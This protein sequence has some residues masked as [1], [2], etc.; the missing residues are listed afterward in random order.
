MRNL[1]ASTVVHPEG[2]VPRLQIPPR[3]LPKLKSS[4]GESS[5][6][7]IYLRHRRLI[8]GRINSD[9]IVVEMGEQPLPPREAGQIAALIED[10]EPFG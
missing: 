5:R 9:G 4:S 1:S 2:A 8:C 6:Y 3:L 10:I 7:R